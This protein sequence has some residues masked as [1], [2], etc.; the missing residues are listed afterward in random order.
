MDVAKNG[1]ILWLLFS[2]NLQVESDKLYATCM[3]NGLQ[4]IYQRQ[5][6]VILF[7]FFRNGEPVEQGFT[8]DMQYNQGG[9]VR[10]K[11]KEVVMDTSAF[12]PRDSF[13]FLITYQGK[14]IYSGWYRV[15]W[16][17]HGG[18]VMSGLLDDYAIQFSKFKKETEDYNAYYERNGLYYVF[19][20][21]RRRNPEYKPDHSSLI[22]Y[23]VRSNTVNWMSETYQFLPKNHGPS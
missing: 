13:R 17:R 9:I 6:P 15:E 22:Y 16:V 21:I 12:Q 14:S 8:V 18:R 5:S 19:L 10:C 7:S 2:F 20:R 23:C 4:A 1:I 11:L 3:S